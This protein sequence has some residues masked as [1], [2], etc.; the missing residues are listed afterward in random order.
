MVIACMYH[1]FVAVVQCR[2]ARFRFLTL[3]VTNEEDQ[4]RA[5]FGAPGFEDQTVA[6]RWVQDNADELEVLSAQIL[7]F[8]RNAGAWSACYLTC[9]AKHHSLLSGVVMQVGFCDDTQSSQRQSQ[10]TVIAQSLQLACS[11]KDSMFLPYLQYLK[12]S[13]LSSYGSDVNIFCTFEQKGYH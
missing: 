9:N 4:E 12:A 13:G 5:R 11:G 6:V 7:V 10:S 8:G 1:I 2:L 3:D